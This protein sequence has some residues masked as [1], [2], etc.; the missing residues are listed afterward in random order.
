M[1]SIFMLKNALVKNFRNDF[2]M[3]KFLKKNNYE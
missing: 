2:E 3:I 1:H